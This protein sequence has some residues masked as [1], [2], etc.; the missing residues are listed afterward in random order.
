MT[1]RM[2][3]AVT[4]PH[5]DVL[6]HCTGRLLVEHGY[7]AFAEQL[8]AERRQFLLP[9]FANLALLRVEAKSEGEVMTDRKSTRLNSSH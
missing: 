3:A 5:T 1:E 7:P 4:N 9:P 2:L 6:G 8:M